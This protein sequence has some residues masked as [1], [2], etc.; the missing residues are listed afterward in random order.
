MLEQALSKLVNGDNCTVF[1]HNMAYAR[2]LRDRFEE[3]LNLHE[4]YWTRDRSNSLRVGENVIE[5]RP[6]S[7]SERL[8]KGRAAYAEFTDHYVWENQNE[9]ISNRPH[10]GIHNRRRRR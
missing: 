8:R 1:A 4:I 5:F 2:D 3:L 10:S 6:S 9:Q 7:E